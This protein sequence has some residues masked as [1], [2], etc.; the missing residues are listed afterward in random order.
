MIVRDKAEER[1]EVRSVT[2]FW[3]LNEEVLKDS[4]SLSLVLTSGIDTMTES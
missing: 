4:T 1:F 2:G 3:K